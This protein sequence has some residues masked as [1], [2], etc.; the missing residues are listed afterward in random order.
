MRT[1]FS[2][3]GSPQLQ[4]NRAKYCVD[5][6][7][8]GSIYSCLGISCSLFLKY[9]HKGLWYNT[10]ATIEEKFTH[11]YIMGRPMYQYYIKSRP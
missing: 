1:V 10:G 3:D 2:Q 9:S 11:N 5:N 7:G 6:I 8:L 4:R